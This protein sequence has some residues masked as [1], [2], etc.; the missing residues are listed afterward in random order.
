MN[1]CHKVTETNF[2]TWHLSMNN[3]LEAAERTV[4][5]ETMYLLTLRY[6]QDHKE[7]NTLTA[8]KT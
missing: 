6:S 1:P 2:M 5:T 8:A 4:E 7:S 3:K